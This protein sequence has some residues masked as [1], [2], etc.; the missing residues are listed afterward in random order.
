VRSLLW[1]LCGFGGAASYLAA[2]FCL[3]V[4]RVESA[5]LGWLVSP[6]FSLLLALGFTPR[7]PF[8]LFFLAACFLGIAGGFA[9]GAAIGA[10]VQLLF[11][12]RLRSAGR[13]A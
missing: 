10:L 3:Y 9:A 2:V 6:P 5:P 11:H 8:L 1:L 12:R 4:M 13:A 7:E